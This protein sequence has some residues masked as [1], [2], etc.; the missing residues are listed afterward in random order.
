MIEVEQ[1]ETFAKQFN[2]IKD[3]SLKRRISKIII[4]ISFNP[5]IGKPMR[6]GRKGSRELYVGS[7]RLA[8]IYYKEE[9]IIL[10]LEIYHKDEQ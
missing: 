4:K 2:K 7:H 8:Y 6:F 3:K 9:L 10:M 1:S 5:F